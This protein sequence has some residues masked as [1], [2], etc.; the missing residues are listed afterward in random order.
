M[1]QERRV[2][3]KRTKKNTSKSKQKKENKK[4]NSRKMEENESKRKILN[5]FFFITKNRGKI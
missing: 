2:K 4:K 5:K 1:K 3:G